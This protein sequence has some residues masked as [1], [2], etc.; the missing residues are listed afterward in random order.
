MEKIFVKIKRYATVSVIFLGALATLTA[1]G[2]GSKESEKAEHTSSSQSIKNK[3]SL[4]SSSSQS[5]SIS[6]SSSSDI[7]P[8]STSQYE[9]ANSS[10][11]LAGDYS[12]LN[13][14]WQTTD[15]G[16]K[17]VLKN[18]TIIFSSEYQRVISGPQSKNGII[19]AGAV[20]LG[21]YM[22]FM[23][24]AANSSPTFANSS[25]TDKTDRTKDRFAIT[26]NDE[27]MEIFDT[28]PTSFFYKISND[29]TSP[30]S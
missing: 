11:I 14:T 30:N 25:Q 22:G 26:S 5:S 2:S 28:N 9:A 4:P 20:N 18:G 24:A 17:A 27:G 8:S 1:C 15:G 29:T 3:E 7:S 6:T 12:S 23:F 16:G 19:M 10:Q 13:G 21:K